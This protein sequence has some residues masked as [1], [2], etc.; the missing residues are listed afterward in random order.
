M[1]HTSTYDELNNLFKRY[2]KRSRQGDDYISYAEH[3]FSEGSKLL[4]ENRKWV[5]KYLLKL[6]SEI[7]LEKWVPLFFYLKSV[8]PLLPEAVIEKSLDNP[9][10]VADILMLIPELSLGPSR[11]LKSFLR[12]A[13][14]QQEAY[15]L[16]ESLLEKSAFAA[17]I[18]ESI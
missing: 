14:E 1:Q 5:V 12:K 8:L 18:L 10:L 15:E 11:H 9:D 16:L 2:L 6:Y 7:K 13:N 3:I 17:A 4:I